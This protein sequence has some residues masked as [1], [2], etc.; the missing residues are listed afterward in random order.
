MCHHGPTRRTGRLLSPLAPSVFDCRPIVGRSVML[1]NLGAFSWR[2]GAAVGIRTHRECIPSLPFDTHAQP[3]SVRGDA[4]TGPQSS[5]VREGSI[6]LSLSRPAI[7]TTIRPSRLLF[8]Y[9]SA[10]GVPSL[11]TL[12][13]QQSAQ[14]GSV[15]LVAA[16]CKASSSRARLHASSH[17]SPRYRMRTCA[18]RPRPQGAW[19]GA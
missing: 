7:E 19:Q 18:G 11:H 2:R 3:S 9:S 14:R 4:A 16:T 10:R 15:D 6:D 12:A 8:R 13:R 5:S 17:L 1:I